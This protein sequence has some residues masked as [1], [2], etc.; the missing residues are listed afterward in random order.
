M[1][2]IKTAAKAGCQIGTC[3]AA[4]RVI[5][6]TGAVRGKRLKNTGKGLLGDWTM[7]LM[8]IK[9]MI[10]GMITTVVVWLASRMFG[11]SAPSPAI[12]LA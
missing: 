12:K 9:G 1:A 11:T 5:I 10:N 7:T 3:V 2:A 4:S 8:N 6:L